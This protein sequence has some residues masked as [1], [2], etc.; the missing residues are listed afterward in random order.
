M[1]RIVTSAIAGGLLVG[2]GVLLGQMLATGNAGYG[3]GALVFH[4]LAIIAVCIAPYIE[5]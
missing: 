5:Q 3:A 4:L 1:T 2:A